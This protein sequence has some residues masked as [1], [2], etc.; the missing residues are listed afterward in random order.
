M[1]EGLCFKAPLQKRQSLHP[2]HVLKPHK[3]TKA[4]LFGHSVIRVKKKFKQE[5]MKIVASEKVLAWMDGWMGLW[6]FVDVC[7]KKYVYYSSSCCCCCY[8][9]GSDHHTFPFKKTTCR[10]H[11]SALLSYRVT[12]TP[13]GELTMV[14][15]LTSKNLVNQIILAAGLEKTLFFLKKINL[16]NFCGVA[17]NPK[18]FVVSLQ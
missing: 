8:C 13:V 7:V 1:R 5:C 17:R 18:P 3:N 6:M 15:R 4:E 12:W 16:R 10:N 11:L 2:L 14:N 9:L